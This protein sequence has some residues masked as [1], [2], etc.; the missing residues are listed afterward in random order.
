MRITLLKNIFFKVVDTLKK[1]K[2]I[3]YFAKQIEYHDQKGK[4]HEV[5]DENTTMYLDY[6]G[7]YGELLGFNYGVH[8]TEYPAL[9]RI[10][11]LFEKGKQK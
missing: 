8:N 3:V 1:Q 9:K 4:L 6:Q 7:N 11:N 5:S 10:G 2:G